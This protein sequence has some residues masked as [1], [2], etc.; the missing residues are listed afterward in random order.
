MPADSTDR[1]SG[2]RPWRK[3]ARWA[4]AYAAVALSHTH[5]ARE[6]LINSALAGD[7]GLSAAAAK[8]ERAH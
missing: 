8:G 3:G 7:G 1:P 5:S 2:T 4:F 6:A